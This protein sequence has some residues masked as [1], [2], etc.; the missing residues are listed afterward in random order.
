MPQ[1]TIT[2]TSSA[3]RTI[4]LMNVTHLPSCDTVQLCIQLPTF[5]NM[6]PLPMVEAVDLG[7]TG[8]SE[9]SVSTYQTM[10]H[11]N[12]DDHGL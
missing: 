8:S 1:K 10:G 6:M 11:H 4:Y 3:A 2:L 12:V 7:V 9:M 5:Q